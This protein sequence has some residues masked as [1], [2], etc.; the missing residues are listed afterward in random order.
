[1]GRAGL[2]PHD[3]GNGQFTPFQQRNRKFEK[4]VKDLEWVVSLAAAKVG[5]LQLQLNLSDRHLQALTVG[6][7]GRGANGRGGERRSRLHRI[8]FF[9]SAVLCKGLKWGRGFR[10]GCWLLLGGAMGP[11]CAC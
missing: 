5:E 2:P 9:C 3:K 6:R 10:S 7:G 4:E 8:V 11:R 1:M